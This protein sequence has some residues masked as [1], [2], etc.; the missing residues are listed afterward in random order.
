MF[1]IFR[2]RIVDIR[3]EVPEYLKLINWNELS[4]EHWQGRRM[5]QAL[6]E[7]KQS[8]IV[9]WTE[10]SVSEWGWTVLYS[11]STHS[12]Q[13]A[14][15][16]TSSFAEI[17]QQLSGLVHISVVSFEQFETGFYQCHHQCLHT[18]HFFLSQHDWEFLCFVRKLSRKN[19]W[20]INSYLEL[21]GILLKFLVMTSERKSKSNAMFRT[22]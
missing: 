17:I 16:N 5:K 1:I 9:Y 7:K 20:L 4:W 12:L 11:V 6:C 18:F 10:R 21:I 19:L 3:K 22:N 15:H 2:I 14:T 13:H 8:V